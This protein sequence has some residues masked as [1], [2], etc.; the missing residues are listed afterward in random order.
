MKLLLDSCM[1]HKAKDLL[2][3]AG[4]DVAWIGDLPSDPGDQEIL[5]RA[6]KEKRILITLDKDFGELA[7][8]QGRPHHGM[9]RLVNFKALRQG[10]VCLQIL[11]DYSK[12]LENLAILTVEP[13]RVRL[14]ST[15]AS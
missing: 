15:S 5:E 7:V 12:D 13:G 11:K 9:V 2:V 1:S 4:H 8:A 3:E 10:Q 6:N 14:R